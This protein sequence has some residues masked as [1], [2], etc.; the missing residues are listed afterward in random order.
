MRWLI[1]FMLLLGCATKQQLSNI[2]NILPYVVVK[3]VKKRY[4]N[5][6]LEVDFRV[7]N[8]QNIPKKI[9]Y[10]VLW[11]KNNFLV[12]KTPWILADLDAF[13]VKEFS[14]LSN[15]EADNFEI[16]VKGLK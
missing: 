11:Y 12:G 13:E 10:R 3:D 2:Q 7:K 6:F 16:K 15:V 5:G 14:V 9:E 8:I 4:I 1:V